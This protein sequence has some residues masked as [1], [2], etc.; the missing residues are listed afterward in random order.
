MKRRH[1]TGKKILDAKYIYWRIII[2]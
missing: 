2:R 1:Y